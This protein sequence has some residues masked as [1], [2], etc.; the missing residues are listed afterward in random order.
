[1]GSLRRWR[2]G[3]LRSP[4]FWGVALVVVAALVTT[5]VVLATR[6]GPSAPSPTTSTRSVA[7][8]DSVPYG[9]GLANPYP[10]PQLGLPP[11]AVSQGPSALAYP[12][13]VAHALELTMRIRP[14]NC[15]LTDDQLAIS[16][17]VVDPADNTKRDGQCLVPPQQARNLDD[18]LA[19]AGLADHPARLVLLQDGADDIDF[20]SCLENQLARCGRCPFRPR[21]CLCRQRLGHP[22]GGDPARPR[23]CRS[24]P[25]HRGG[26]ATWLTGSSSSTI[27]QPVPAPSQIA[28]DSGLSGLGTNLVCTGLRANAAATYASAKVVLAALNHSIASAV[29]AARATASAT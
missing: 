15:H 1:M 12:S 26:C 11:S 9:H 24:D 22:A 17:A 2:G 29:A 16:G 5:A 28:D 23:A 20:A 8:G 10:T 27:I 4:V 13:L 25:G 19:A 7:L 6:P 14:T 18:E 3:A 21:E